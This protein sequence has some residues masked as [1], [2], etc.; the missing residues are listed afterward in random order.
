VLLL[1]AFFVTKGQV[2]V[3]EVVAFVGFAQLMIN[4]LDQISNFINLAISSQA[5]LKDFFEME[6]STVHTNTPENLPSLQNVKGEIQFHHVSYKFLNSSQ[7]VFDISFKVKAGQTV[8]IVGPTGAGKTTLINLLQ[9]VYDP[10]IGHI[11]IDEIDIRTVNRESLRKALATVF[12]DSGLFNRSIRD[13]ISI[14]KITATD[15]ELYE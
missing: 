8:A 15:E 12:Q 13:N 1:G 2:R 7:G 5:K 6:D 4:R 9:R 11:S 14:G 10:T 3:G